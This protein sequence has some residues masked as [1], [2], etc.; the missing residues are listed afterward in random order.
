MPFSLKDIDSFINNHPRLGYFILFFLLFF[1]IINEL[2]KNHPLY[3]QLLAKIL[4]PLAKL[5]KF[6]KLQK[7]AIKSDIQGKINFVTNLI[8][9]EIPHEAIRPLEIQWIKDLANT[10][11]I[12]ENKILVRM[13]PVDSQD[14][15]LLNV[16]QPYLESIL[17]PKSRL[18]IQETQKK[19]IIYFTTKEIISSNENL[20]RKFHEEYYLP[21]CK[22]HQ[23]IE[24]YFK[25]IDLTYK[26]GLFFSIGIT[27][28]EEAANKHRFKRT[29][30]GS[31]FAQILDHLVTFIN[32]LNT[33]NNIN[34]ELKWNFLGSGISYGLLLVARPNVAMI[35]K[36]SPYVKRA[37]EK[38]KICE[39]LFIVFSHR[40]KNF[41]YQVANNIESELDINFVEELKT[42]FD[43][44]GENNGI[45]RIYVK[46]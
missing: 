17:I 41:G 25:K 19:A 26:K 18:L 1:W 6:K 13:K 37:E 2:V 20:L 9:K 10:N 36:I 31:D 21:D 7:A 39:M 14:E 46:K 11:F 5:F 4:I 24:E 22:K 12:Q 34:S 32:K 8:S 33:Q 29:D 30:L 42:K 38:L 16:A 43:Y 15:N 23:S 28:L 40:E 45:V 27:A 35:G 44:R 3:L